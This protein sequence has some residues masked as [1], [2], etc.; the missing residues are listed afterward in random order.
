[1]AFFE[2][3][4]KQKSPV[5]PPGRR[6]PLA[7]DQASKRA[8]AFSYYA[9]RSAPQANTGRGQTLEAA[10]MD[11][12]MTKPW[13]LSRPAITTSAVVVLALV[14]YLTSLS[15]NPKIVTLTTNGSGYFLQDTAVY[16]QAAAKSLGHSLVNR[17]KLTIDSSAIS[18][19][20][21]KQ[22]P[23]L[24]SATVTT[25]LVGHQATIFI[26]PYEPSFMLSTVDNKVF[27]LDTNGRALASNSQITDAHAVHVPTLEDK[28]GLSISLG[29][30][31]LP[32]DTVHFITEVLSLLAAAKVG[33]TQLV[34]PPSSSEL[35]VYVSGQPYFVKFN[36]QG[37]AKL[38]VGTFLATQERLARDKVTPTQ[39]IDVR[40]GERAYYR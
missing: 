28:S 36:L 3:Y 25:P 26:T 24:A 19:D 9:Q 13:Y 21:K 20:L 29:T 17:N 4:K 23:E 40:V 16:Q 12:S 34:L 2:K 7:T 35:D 38:E 8:Q 33:Y 18:S 6:R 14:L 11:G 10:E 1:M 32:A 39:Y 30:Q 27:L 22:Y 5:D 37:D 15:G 31:A